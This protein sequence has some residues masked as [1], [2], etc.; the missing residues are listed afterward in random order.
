MTVKEQNQHD[1][2]KYIAQVKL[3]ENVMSRIGR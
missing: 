1:E 2:E 3:Y